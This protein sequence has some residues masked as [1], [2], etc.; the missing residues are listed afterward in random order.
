MI[1]C[2]SVG[3]KAY[4]EQMLLPQPSL[5]LQQRYEGM[6]N[7]RVASVNKSLKAVRTNG[8]LEVLEYRLSVYMA[9]ELSPSRYSPIQPNS[10]GNHRGVTIDRLG[11]MRLG[12]LAYIPLSVTG[13]GEQ[14]VG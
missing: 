2:G 6:L 5:Y 10:P 4:K 13:R 8:D 12:L 7:V 14:K 11:L 3:L 1:L 9:Q